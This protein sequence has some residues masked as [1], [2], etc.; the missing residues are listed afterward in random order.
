MPKCITAFFSVTD[1]KTFNVGD[2]ISV[3]KFDSLPSGYK[4]NFASD[5]EPVVEAKLIKK[6]PK[7]AP[8]PEAP[9][10]E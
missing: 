5:D 9:A 1:D 6:A 4:E 7:E 10:L 3:E 8:E 2:D